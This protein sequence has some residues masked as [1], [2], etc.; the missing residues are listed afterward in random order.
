MAAAV[1]DFRP[2]AGLVDPGT[3]KLRRMGGGLTLELEATPD[4]IG[5]IAKNRRNGQFLVGFALEPRG[6]ML[7]SA[8]AKLVRKGLDLIVANPLE[9]M[10][11][12]TIE[13]AAVG[14]GPE[15]P[16]VVA[17]TGG[18]ISKERFGEWLLDVIEARRVMVRA[19]VSP[20]ARVAGR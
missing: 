12:E 5:G 9:T 7:D 10:D 2:K 13:A 16:G 11:S 6:E 4:L 1:A 17:E 20:G 15:G 3:G 19:G 18:A 14:M 8:R